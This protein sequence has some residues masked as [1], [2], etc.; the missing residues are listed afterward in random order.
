MRA[1]RDVHTDVV[2]LLLSA[3]ADINHDEKVFL[4]CIVSTHQSQNGGTSLSWAA[5]SGHT[6]VVKLKS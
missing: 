6:E 3:G 5:C 1:A 4:F 2:K